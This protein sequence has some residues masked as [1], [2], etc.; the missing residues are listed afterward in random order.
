MSQCLQVTLS[1]NQ[2]GE[3]LSSPDSLIITHPGTSLP[4]KSVASNP[5]FWP[6]STRMESEV[7]GPKK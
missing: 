3:L 1:I 2:L 5:I 6:N 4:G 7:S